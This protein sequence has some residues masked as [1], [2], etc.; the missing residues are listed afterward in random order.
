M[1]GGVLTSYAQQC[2]DIDSHVWKKGRKVYYKIGSNIG[3]EEQSQIRSGMGDWNTAN[4]S[5][6]SGVVFQEATGTTTPQLTINSGPAD[7]RPEK[8]ERAWG[9]DGLLTSATL[10]LDP[11]SKGPDGIPVYDKNQPGYN[12]IWRKMTGHAVGHSMGL[13]DIPTGTDGCTQTDGGS[14]MNAICKTNDMGNNMPTKPTAC[15]NTAVQSIYESISEACIPE[16][17]TLSGPGWYWYQSR[18][19]C[20]RTTT[21]ILIDTNGDGFALTDFTSGVDFDF[22]ADGILEHLSWTAAG[23]DDAWLALDRNGNGTI[24]NGT[25]LFGNLTPQP[26][27][28]EPNGFLAL[29]DY[30]KAVYGGNDDGVIDSRDVIFNSLLLWQDTNH[31]GISEP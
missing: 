19:S 22:N 6:G 14:I 9:S 28:D 12:T 27:S 20:V 16:D 8:I 29:A 2:P 31:N 30:D 1:V 18:C 4:A 15:D 17:C 24:D 5:N 13:K 25:E 7:G 10:T 21:P 11:N 26:L 3:T 23:T